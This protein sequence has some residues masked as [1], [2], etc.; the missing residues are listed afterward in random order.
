MKAPNFGAALLRY[1]FAVASRAVAA[2]GGGYLLASA[3]AA[4][5]A[6]YVARRC[7]GNGADAVVR[8]LCLRGHLGLRHL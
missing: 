6:A 5:L 8:G 4:C 3:A 7:R 1:R 2:I